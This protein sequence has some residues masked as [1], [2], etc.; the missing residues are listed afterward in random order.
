[1]KVY[2]PPLRRPRIEMVPLIDTFF[3][4]LAFFIS[5]VLSMEVV[6]GLPVE[7]PR[8]GSDSAVPREDRW[9]V[10]L[11]AQGGLELEGQPVNLEI[12]EVRLRE[13][14]AEKN[15]LRVGVRADRSA[16]YERVIE[17]LGAIRQAGV[18]RVSLL[19]FPERGRKELSR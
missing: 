8:A 10:T 5:A 15:D 19:T 17:V 1:M 3:L 18:T 14:A 2:I 6:R 11:G 4:M 9:I 16:P 12:L 13:G 7:L